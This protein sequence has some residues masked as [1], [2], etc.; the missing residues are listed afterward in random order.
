MNDIN[1]QSTDLIGD[2]YTNYLKKRTTS[3]K[4]NIRVPH[5]LENGMTGQISR[6]YTQEE[7]INKIKTDEE[8]AKKWDVI[9][10]V[11]ELSREERYNLMPTKTGHSKGNIENRKKIN[12]F[13]GNTTGVSYHEEWLDSFCIPTKSISLT[14]NN[15]TEVIYE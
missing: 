11:R 4:D 12:N 14:Y 2:T 10:E 6:P 15:Q 3:N 5:T 9:V 7:F 8:F 1:N 13:E